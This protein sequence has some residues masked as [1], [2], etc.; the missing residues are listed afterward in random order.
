MHASSA[1]GRGFWPQNLIPFANL[2]NF[3]KFSKGWGVEEHEE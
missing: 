1:G 2:T 3:L